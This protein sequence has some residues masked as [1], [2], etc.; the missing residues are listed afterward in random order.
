MF[1][2]IGINKFIVNK[3]KKRHLSLTQGSELGA[4]HGEYE[5]NP[6]NTFCKEY[7]IIHETTPPY[8]PESNG[9]VEIKNRTLKETIHP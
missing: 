2:S 9:V 4:S 1:N 7:E 5:S 6:F 8:Y 3:K